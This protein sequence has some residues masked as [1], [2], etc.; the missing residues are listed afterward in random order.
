MP[1]AQTPLR[2]ERS[3]IRFATPYLEVETRSV[4]PGA[5]TIKCELAHASHTPKSKKRRNGDRLAIPRPA[6][7]P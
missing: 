5:R 2:F 4:S 3:P 1:T 7:S 6:R